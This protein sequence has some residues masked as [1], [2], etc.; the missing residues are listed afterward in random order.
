MKFFGITKEQIIEDKLLSKYVDLNKLFVSEKPAHF[1]AGDQ[2]FYL[3]GNVYKV[4]EKGP[5]GSQ[6]EALQMLAEYLNEKQ[7]KALNKVDGEFTLII[8]KG[9]EITI[10]RDFK[11]TGPQIFYNSEIF[12]NDLKLLLDI[13]KDAPEPD[14]QALSFFLM[15]GFTPPDLTGLKDIKRLPGGHVLQYSSQGMLVKKLEDTISANNLNGHGSVDDYSKTFFNI[16]TDAIRNR[17][18]G[19]NNIGL[20][21]SGGYDSGGNLAGIRNFYD[22]PLKSYTVS[23]KNNPHSELEFVKLMA[24]TFKADLVNYEIDGS[25]ICFLP[26]IVKHTGIPFQESGLMINYLVMKT[27]G[28]DNLDIVLGGDG[29]D[30]LFGTANKELAMKLFSLNSGISMLQKVLSSMIGKNENSTFTQKLNLY[31]DKIQN[32]VFPDHWGFNANQLTNTLDIR[33]IIN[34]DKVYTTSYEK[35]YENR[36]KNIDIVITAFNVILFK[37]ARMAELFNVPLS[38]PY[39]SREVYEFVNTLPMEMKIHGT[40]RELLKGKGVSKY[41]HKYTYKPLIPQQVTGRKKQGGFV[42]LAMFFTNDERNKDFFH[43]IEKSELLNSLLKDHKQE[44]EVLR[45]TVNNPET[46]FWYQQVYYSRMFNMMVLAIWEKLYLQK[47]NVE[48]I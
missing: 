32:V 15:L 24:K 38:F 1:N 30:Q 28:K 22:G 42:P 25:E 9:E 16:H 21:L 48:I 31:N 44:I 6:H 40:F 37:A 41:I 35:I 26:E 8:N 12:S 18:N 47:E 10:Y 20:L 19:K 13:R 4:P 23:F 43:L 29:N 46:W 2:Q 39:L 3:F 33:K 36:R 34:L 17:I 45:K 14:Y 27:A 11:G 7:L 5:V